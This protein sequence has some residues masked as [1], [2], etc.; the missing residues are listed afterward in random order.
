MNWYK[1]QLLLRGTITRTV[2]RLEV[3]ATVQGPAAPR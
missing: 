2:T 3:V 1:R